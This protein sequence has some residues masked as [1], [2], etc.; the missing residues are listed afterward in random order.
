MPMQFHIIIK[1]E[2]K[3][4]A[5]KFLNRITLQGAK[6]HEIQYVFDCLRGVNGEMDFNQIIPMPK[7]LVHMDHSVRNNDALAYYNAIAF[8]DF[9]EI[10]FR[11]RD[12]YNENAKT[13]KQYLAFLENKYSNFEKVYLD[14]GRVLD[15]LYEYG[16]YL[17][18]LDKKYG[19]HDWFMW[20]IDNWNCKW[21][22]FDISKEG[23]TLTFHTI[24]NSA[25]HLILTASEKHPEV[26]FVYETCNE[27]VTV[28]GRL[29]LKAGEI[30]EEVDVEEGSKEEIL[31]GIEIL[32]YTP[33]YVKI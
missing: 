30:I 26:E 31:L 4:M 28:V 24:N 32:G 7:E 29:T 15:N 27:D 23:N 11:I 6:D 3:N 10:D 5:N 16:K 20:S 33:D 25:F 19:A 2:D 9:K 8:G 12:P 14:D 18:F 21:N 17:R 13:R 22:A 1:K